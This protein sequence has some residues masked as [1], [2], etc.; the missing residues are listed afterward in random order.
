M[1][2]EELGLLELSRKVNSATKGD[3]F[4]NSKSTE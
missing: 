3:N 2:I 1:K 4:T